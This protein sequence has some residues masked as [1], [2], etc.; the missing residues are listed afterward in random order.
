MYKNNMLLEDAFDH[1]RSR[2]GVISPNL[3][4]MQQLKEFEK[5]IFGEK[6]YDIP[7]SVSSISTSL[8]SVD[9]DISC[10]S[11]S[12]SDFSSS[13]G[14]AFDF[15]FASSSV[16]PLSPRELVSPS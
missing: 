9:F 15:T 7:D 12:N 3:N 14:G 5:D 2:R 11:T 8:A 10:S 16:P 1:V 4:F 6:V 13:G